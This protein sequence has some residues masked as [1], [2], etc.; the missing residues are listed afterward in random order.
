MSDARVTD[1]VIRSRL[2]ANGAEFV[3]YLAG[4]EQP[5]GGPFAC[6]GEAVNFALGQASPPAR[7]F[8][9]AL[10][11]CGRSIGTPMR[12]RLEAP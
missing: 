1:V 7:L 6:L 8:Y 12:L 2:L 4:A 3:V 11:E 5:L 10:D 9:D